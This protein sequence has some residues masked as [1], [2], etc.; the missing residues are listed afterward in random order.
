M[1]AAQFEMLPAFALQLAVRVEAYCVALRTGANAVQG[2]RDFDATAAVNA[3]TE[4]ARPVSALWA[5]WG[6]FAAAVADFR[7]A[8]I[9][10]PASPQLEAKRSALERAAE[11]L[12][13]KAVRW[14]VFEQQYRFPVPAD[15]AQAFIE[16]EAAR[17][18]YF[19][20]R[21]SETQAAAAESR[22]LHAKWEAKCAA[23][24]LEAVRLLGA[25]N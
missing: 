3:I 14:A 10:E 17:R 13:L 22:D 15:V 4:L 21:R 20:I 8:E 5:E 18:V 11:A 2:P 6:R 7:L 12:M 25:Q 16:W 9:M 23:L 1:A 24:L 19:Q